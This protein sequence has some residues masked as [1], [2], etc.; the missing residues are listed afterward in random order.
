MAAPFVVTCAS[1]K[2]ATHILPHL[3]GHMPL[4]LV[5]NS[6]KS[7]DRLRAERPRVEVV[8]ADLAQPDECRRVLAGAAGVLHI[9]PSFHA[10]ETE[11]GYNMVDAAAGEAAKPGGAFKHFVYSSVLHPQFRKMMNHDGK[12]LVEEYLLESGVPFT[13]LQP[14][15]FLDLFPV[16]ALVGQER[17]VYHA[18]WDTSVR[19][20]FVTLADLGEAMARVVMEGARHLYATYELCST[21][22]LSY[23]ELAAQVS[24]VIGKEIELKQRPY[25]EAV[26]AML[27]ILFGSADEVPSR[28]RDAAERMLLFYNRRGLVGNPLVLEWLLGRRA[29]S[30]AAWAKGKFDEASR[31]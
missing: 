7:I 15:H 28:T 16:G 14:T 12:R 9:G 5:A 22:P 17:P 4:R 8:Q 21:L 11:I 31:G 2:Q 26:E 25:A 23:D 10:H 24:R 29:T 6:Q 18:N 19:F 30:V 3:D 1:G 27:A 13:I 20:S